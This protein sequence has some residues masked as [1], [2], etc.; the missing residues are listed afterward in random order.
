MN[1]ADNGAVQ[2]KEGKIFQ[3]TKLFIAFTYTYSEVLDDNKIGSQLGI[4]YCI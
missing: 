2:D 3:A 1:N 4:S